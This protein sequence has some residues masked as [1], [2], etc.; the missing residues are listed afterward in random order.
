MLLFHTILYVSNNIHLQSSAIVIGMNEK[1]S[2]HPTTTASSPSSSPS[3]SSNCNIWRIDPTGQF[4]KCHLATIGRGAGYIEHAMLL[5][6]YKWKQEQKNH[7]QN[8]QQDNEN[9]T[10]GSS[11]IE[12]KD[13]V[14]QI[15]NEDVKQC[16]DEMTFDD[17]M[18]FICDC[19]RHVYG[20]QNEHDLWK[21]DLQ[22]L[23]ITTSNTETDS[24]DSDGTSGSR[25]HAELI[26][27]TILRQCLQSKVRK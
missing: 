25:S 14:S 8:H 27:D 4:W 19:I 1:I 3:S 21:V 17:V 5:H 26:H 16:W 6:V 12:M 9:D 15:T 24:N 22:G 13:L 10:T 23:L 11:S 20:V 2:H 18:E 7:Q